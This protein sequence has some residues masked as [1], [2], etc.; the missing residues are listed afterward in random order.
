MENGKY[1]KLVCLFRAEEILIM[2][3]GLAVTGGGVSKF[4]V[5]VFF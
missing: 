3:H 5:D 4:E 1:S 2:G